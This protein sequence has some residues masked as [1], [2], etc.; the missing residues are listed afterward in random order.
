MIEQ[1]VFACVFFTSLSSVLLTIQ[2]SIITA[3]K[4]VN[5]PEWPMLRIH[6]ICYCTLIEPIVSP[7]AAIYSTYNS[8]FFPVYKRGVGLFHP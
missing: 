4:P 1:R 7:V 2:N 5:Y 8:V 3:S 6:A